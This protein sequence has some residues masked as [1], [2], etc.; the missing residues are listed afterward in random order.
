ME[1]QFLGATGTVTGSKYLVTVRNKKILVDCGLFQ[2]LKPLRLRN[3]APLPFSPK[4]LDAL[5]LT[6]AHLDHSGAIPLIVRAGFHKKI[7]CSPATKDLCE[8]L[9]P[10]SGHIQE[11]DAYFANKHAF[12]KHHPALPLYTQ[13]EA[14]T[15]LKYISA[16]PYHE[17]VSLGDGVTF[18]LI[19]AGHI[20]GASFVR[21]SD[22]DKTLMFS[23]DL[24]RPNDPLMKAPTLIESADYLVVESTYGNRLHDES[25]VKEILADAINRT[26]HRGGIVI[27]PAFAV[28][29]AQVLMYLL[30]QL[31]DEGKIVDVPIYLDSPMATDV[32]NLY[33]KYSDLHRLT[34]D[35]CRKMCASANLVT[36]PDESKALDHQNFPMVI[37]SASGMATGGRVLHHLKAFVSDRRNTVIFAGFQAAG[38][39]GE[40]MVNGATEIKIHG[41]FVPIRAEVMIL[42]NLSA[43]A[44]ANEILGWLKHFKKPPRQ[45]FITHGEPAPADAL[46]HKIENRLQW[47]C[48]VPEYL[49]KVEL[50]D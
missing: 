5:I 19:P 46:R 48:Y 47:S 44:D 1:I 20:L 25:D 21:I 27:I 30:Q 41:N 18:E 38:T 11:E 28:G 22:G 26:V 29:R 36:T 37:V 7:Y 40:A 10:D 24:G 32:T 23:G 16:V 34:P 4:S 31:K 45:T 15:S 14:E 12:S 17:K 39:R 50:G 3:W 33:R 9:L 43:H 42:H 13:E 49:E 6:H 2:G 8:I 35:E